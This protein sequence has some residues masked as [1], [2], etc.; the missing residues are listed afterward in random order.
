MISLVIS[1]I[2]DD[3][4]DVEEEDILFVLTFSSV[5][6]WDWDEGNWLEINFKISLCFSECL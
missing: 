5:C 1:D 4:W 2:V 6:D 3:E